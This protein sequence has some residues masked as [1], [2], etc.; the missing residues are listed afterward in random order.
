[1]N[2]S[3]CMAE[4]L[5]GMAAN[6]KY[7]SMGQVSVS[8]GQRRAMSS[9]FSTECQTCQD[10]VSVGA[11]EGQ[12]KAEKIRFSFKHQLLLSLGFM[13]KRLCRI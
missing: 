11:E 9:S 5:M 12:R 4:K 1:M 3:N 13:Q 8:T 2:A 7:H 6:S 10:T